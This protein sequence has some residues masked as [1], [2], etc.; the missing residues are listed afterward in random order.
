MALRSVRAGEV[1]HARPLDVDHVRTQAYS[2]AKT[3]AFQ[4]FR[5]ELKAGTQLVEHDVAGAMIF[6]CS[7]G[8]LIFTAN[9]RSHNIHAGDLMHLADGAPHHVFA[10]TDSSALVTVLAKVNAPSN[11]H[12]KRNGS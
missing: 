2:L 5:L 3:D 12:N 9:G 1:A 10:T 6:L 4:I 11:Q 8:E 7:E